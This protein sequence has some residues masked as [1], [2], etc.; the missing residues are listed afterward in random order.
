MESA[1]FLPHVLGIRG[2]LKA[3][4]IEQNFIKKAPEKFRGFVIFILRC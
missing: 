4:A 3:W 2:W 1:P